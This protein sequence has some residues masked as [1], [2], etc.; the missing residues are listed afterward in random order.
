M[1][2]VCSPVL[3]LQEAV[4]EDGGVLRTFA[5]VAE[6]HLG[7]AK[8]DGVLASG[9]TVEFL[10]LSLLNILQQALATFPVSCVADQQVGVSMEGSN[11]GAGG[12]TWMD[13]VKR[14]VPGW[15]SRFR[16]P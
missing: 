13:S 1:H 3:V 11:G 8:T 6:G 10:E 4:S 2:N 7:L 14:G 5:V 12:W 9:D 15:G 16:W